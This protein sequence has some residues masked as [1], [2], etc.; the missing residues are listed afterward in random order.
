MQV[1]MPYCFW[2]DMSICQSVCSL[3]F[4]MPTM[5]AIYL[6]KYKSHSLESWP[7]SLIGDD[8]LENKIHN[9]QQSGWFY[10]VLLWMRHMT[11][12]L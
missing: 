3:L 10:V 4:I 1:D 6:A 2:L 9:H 11:T 8:E 5:S 12:A 7:A